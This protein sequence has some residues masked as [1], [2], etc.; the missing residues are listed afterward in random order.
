MNV[1]GAVDGDA[2]KPEEDA[3][4]V[5]AEGLDALESCS[6]G[7]LEDVLGE[8]RHGEAR[9]DGLAV[10]LVS[11]PLKEDP[12]GLSVTLT[13]PGD[14]VSLVLDWGQVAGVLARQGRLLS[15]LLTTAEGTQSYTMHSSTRPCL[16]SRNTLCAC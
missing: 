14:D 16:C 10:E 12:C 2:S 13:D 4:V 9:E 7:V 5:A 3:S 6:K 1:D 8:L 15:S 11:E